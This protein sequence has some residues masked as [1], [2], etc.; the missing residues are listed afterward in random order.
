MDDGIAPR[1]TSEHRTS[2]ILPDGE[3]DGETLASGD[4]GSTES[5]DIIHE[6][7]DQDESSR[8]TGFLGK[9]S[10]ISWMQRA[11]KQATKHLTANTEPEASSSG[12]NIS[13]AQAS[14]YIN[15]ADTA[16]IDRSQVNPFE[17]PIP[18]V[19][20]AYVTS[21]FDTIH[22]AF[23]IVYKNGFMAVFNQFPRNSIGNLS[24]VNQHWLSQIN[25]VFAIGAKFAYLT[26]AEYRGN[27][28][29]HLI[30]YARARALGL[31]HQKYTDR[32][33]LDQVSCLG[34]LG[35]YLTMDHQINRFVDLT[36]TYSFS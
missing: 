1:I 28:T 35:L 29:D 33:E 2:Q 12:E 19:A 36:R 8:A 14:Y 25:I 13:L 21:Y 16:T 18:S 34:L 22:S 24:S 5:L 27:E 3:A 32:A 17:W 11:K 10:E 15:N 31:E 7:V 26:R 20:L 9:G 6:D 30:F 23:P 4:V